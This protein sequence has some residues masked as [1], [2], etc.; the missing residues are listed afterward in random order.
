MTFFKTSSIYISSNI[1]NA[2]IPFILLPVLTRYLSQVEYGQIAMFQLL[3][4]ALTAV[5]GM[6]VVGASSRKYYDKDVTFL[7]LQDFNGACFHVLLIST[8]IISPFILYFSDEISRLLAI[9]KDWI[10]TALMMASLSFIVQIRLGQWQIRNQASRYA[11]LQFIR[12]LANIIL[13]LLFVITFNFGADG[14][15]EAQLITALLIGGTS[16]YL[17]RKDDLVSFF[18]FKPLFIREALNFGIPLMPHIIG[19]FLLSS[20]DRY[21]INSRLGLESAAIYMVSYQLSSALGIVF[22]AINKAYTP[23][24][25]ALLKENLIEAKLKVIKATYLYMLFLLLLALLSF[26]IGP[27]IVVFIAGDTYSQAG[28][29]IGYLC[30]GHIFNGMYLMVTNYIFYSKKTK[31]LS[32]VTITSS[33]ISI[34]LMLLLIQYNGLVGVAQA[35]AISQFAR[36]LFTWLLSA[37]VHPMPWFIWK[38]RL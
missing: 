6:G 31:Y 25:F 33:V 1:I 22:D 14:R 8:L 21:I 4:A 15:I 37:K 28:S 12:S 20:A 29:I 24:L 10:L 19:I 17:L 2:V 26:V 35:F 11:V 23:W 5:A 7:N 16:L 34:I 27:F 30:A 13:S 38:N 18:S 3:V 36:F 32:L 9:P